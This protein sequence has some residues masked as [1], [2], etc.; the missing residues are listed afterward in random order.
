MHRRKKIMTDYRDKLTELA[1]KSESNMEGSGSPRHQQV[2]ARWDPSEACRPLLEEAPVFYPTFEEFQDTIQYLA[3][4]RPLAEAYG[5]CKIVP[6]SSWNPPCLLKEKNMWENAEFS[7]RIQVVD[8]LQNRE[9]M[10]KKNKCRKRKRR[11]QSRMGGAPTRRAMSQDKATDKSDEKFGFQSGSDFTLQDFEK[12]ADRFKFCFFRHDKEDLV[13][14]KECEP[15]VE[16]IEGEYWRIIEQPT[17]EVE[18]YYGAD[19]ETG[20]FG[21][22]FPKALDA[23]DN[24]D[25]DLYLKSGWNLNNFPRLQGSLLRFE[26]SDISGVLVPWL[27]VGMCFSSF[28]WHVE[29]HHLYS[30][31]YLH[32]GDPKVWYGVPGSHASAFED[33]MKKHLPDLFDENPD[34]LNELVTQ[35]SPSVLRSEG[36]PVYRIIQHSGDFI[37][38]FPRAY[39]AGFN[40]GFNCAEA[41]NVAPVDWLA[42]G[43]NAVELYSE[44]RRRT[45]LS[46]DKLLFSTAG[47]AV[48]FFCEPEVD[49]KD[50]DKSSSWSWKS[51]CGKDGLLTMAVMT[52]LQM[53]EERLEHLPDDI[54]FRRM[55]TDFDQQSERECFFCSYDLHLS[56]AGCNCSPD[57]FSCLKHYDHLCSCEPESKYVL[58]RYAMDDLWNLVQALEGTL[59]ESSDWNSTFCHN[60]LN[61]SKNKACPTEI[62]LKIQIG[63]SE[64]PLEVIDTDEC[65]ASYGYGSNSLGIP[66]KGFPKAENI[67]EMSPAN[68]S[69]TTGSTWKNFK[70]VEL[71]ESGSVMHGT[72]WCSKEAIFPKGFR[73]RVQFYNVLDPM[74]TCSYISEILDGGFLG[75]LFKVTLEEF[76]DEVFIN[77]SPDDCWKMVL[78]KLNV[79]IARQRGLGTQGLPQ[80]QL[81]QKIDGFKMFGFPSPFILQAV[82]KLDPT[83]QCTKYWSHKDPTRAMHRNSNFERSLCNESHINNSSPQSTYY[84]APAR[85]SLSPELKTIAK[86]QA[87]MSLTECKGSEKVLQRLFE[88]GTLEE[89]KM[90]NRVL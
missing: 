63:S 48:R 13:D 86:D 21:S 90:M 38:T 43:Q 52:R 9:P 76:P 16:D 56:A 49:R 60:L 44:Q 28:C 46:H 72:H 81:L 71:L 47:E 78:Q 31:N 66:L 61:D 64:C 7:T 77:A 88:K 80:T 70:H 8:L 6:P 35:L 26:K 69:S 11:Q 19:L 34:L 18:V 57:Q 79:E 85:R 51:M 55:E 39:H 27:Y 83:R 30:L 29:D 22:G 32:L 54:Q 45:S 62:D 89:L 20:R 40:C 84:S 24:S 50:T 59:N 42:H 1:R 82:E 14:R 15:S 5:I 36:V 2:T 17:D 65:C 73:S 37:L 58:L 68:L 10:R 67:E 41:V 25:S 3:K 87:H 23:D 74:V 4:I 12:Y 33:A 53:E 75:P